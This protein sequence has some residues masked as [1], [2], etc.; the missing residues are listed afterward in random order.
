VSPQ[1]RLDLQGK[2]IAYGRYRLGALSA[3]AF[4]D[5]D[6]HI[7]VD[8]LTIENQDS[9]ITGSGTIGA[10]SREVGF[11]PSAPLA[12]TLTL[13][14]VDIGHFVTDR[15]IR[16]KGRAS[17]AVK[18]PISKPEVTADLYVSGL[19]T[20]GVA[21]G[22][23][24]GRMAFSAGI[25]STDGLKVTNGRSALTLIGWAS[26]FAPDSFAMAADPAIEFHIDRGRLYLE[27]V[28]DDASGAVTVTADVGGTLYALSGAATLMGT[29][30][31]LWGQ[32]VDIAALETRFK[33]DR[34]LIDSLEADIGR[35]KA[36]RARGWVDRRG[37]YDMTAAVR[38]LPLERIDGIVDLKSLMGS[39]SADIHGSGSFEKPYFSGDAT[40]ADLHFD[41]RPL[42]PVRLSFRM[43]PSRIAIDSAIGFDLVGELAWKEGGFS[44]TARFDGTPLGPYF[45]LAGRP[46]LS[47]EMTGSLTFDGNLKDPAQV[48]AEVSLAS[49]RVFLDDRLL[50]SSGEV[51]AR[52]HDGVLE[53]PPTTVIL[54]EDARLKVEGR[55]EVD[56]DIRFLANGDIPMA[57]VSKLADTLPDIDGRLRASVEVTG[58]LT[59]PGIAASLELERVAF[60]IPTLGQKLHGVR[61]TIRATPTQVTID[62]IEG[63]LDDGTFALTGSVG[64][65]NNRPKDV[66][67]SL[68]TTGLPVAVPDTLALEVDSALTL[69]GKREAMS[70][71]G[72]I[73][74]AE[75]VYYK[76]F[77][78]ELTE[79]ISQ[80][81]RPKTRPT[82]IPLPPDITSTALGVSIRSRKPLAV[83]NNLA[84]LAIEPDLKVSGRVRNPILSGRTDIRSGSIRYSNREFIVTRGIVDFVNPYRIEPR[85]DLAAETDIRRWTISLLISGTPDDLAIELASTPPETNE[86]I[87]S[88]LAFGKTTD[89]R[90]SA[91]ATASEFIANTLTPGIKDA[92]GIDRLE[93]N[94][95]T[96]AVNGEEKEEI[97]VTV[98]KDLSRRLSVA[99][100][101]ETKSGERIQRVTSDYK[102]LER[103]IVSAFQDT[104]GDYGGEVKFRLEFR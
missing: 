10:L 41:D 54:A 28:F 1:I 7:R 104:A 57:V 33:D 46:E 60:T 66:N 74:I 3:A 49:T 68:Q 86:E 75:G 23:I 87:L 53:L 93:V 88:L 36:I 96:D 40:I 19:G 81:G 79:A 67:L 43:D 62:R 59:R 13:D 83:D 27:D 103:L 92:T 32:T 82:P 31:S 14:P 21:I 51:R 89:E 90:L 8:G 56:G 61:G 38:N 65:E 101:T 39:L 70:L 63:L 44:V 11:D 45:S 91:G 76:D 84:L 52:M 9:L 5:G 47:G 50:V 29:H 22:D 18:G 77:K 12:A 42:D 78:L 97:K 17:L 100:G 85:I 25:L 37:G 2:D 98:G 58:P 55:G 72:W 48:R 94:Y 71:S 26:P 69:T 24:E 30:L 95:E 35:A 99:Y 34:I 4:V 73:A 6:G 64:L 80:V 102:L 16:G 20:K 15:T